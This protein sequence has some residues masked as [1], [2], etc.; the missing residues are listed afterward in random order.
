MNLSQRIRFLGSYLL[1]A[2]LIGLLR[3]F[4]LSVGL[5]LLM[6][7]VA[8]DFLSS[9]GIPLLF[10]HE[11]WWKQLLAGFF[12]AVAV[13][14]I[15][16]EGYLLDTRRPGRKWQLSILPSLKN[17]PL[18]RSKGIATLETPPIS[19]VEA[20][21][22][23]LTGVISW[24]GLT[25]IVAGIYHALLSNGVSVVDLSPLQRV[26]LPV[27]FAAGTIV[28]LWSQ[29]RLFA[30][31]ES[32]EEP[33]EK[34]GWAGRSWHG[35]E[36]FIRKLPFLSQSDLSISQAEHR[37]RF[38]SGI[39]LLLLICIYAFNHLL[40]GRF[41]QQTVTPAVALCLVASLFVAIYGTFVLL[42][43]TGP[44][45][46]WRSLLTNSSLLVVLFV[47]LMWIGGLS[48]YKIRFEH[49]E[50]YYA[51]P[52]SRYAADKVRIVTL[53][54]PEAADL[55][56]PEE[57][58]P[59][60][61]MPIVI[62]CSSGGGIRAAAWTMAI[63]GRLDHSLVDFTYHV[64]LM[65]GA[66]GGMLGNAYYATTVVPP[67]VSGPSRHSQSWVEDFYEPLSARQMVRNV[68]KDSLSATVKQML[69][70]DLTRVVLPVNGSPG[71]DRGGVL[72]DQW[73]RY[74]GT[75]FSRATFGSL[76]AGEQE[77]WRPTLV[78][79]P[80]L[81]EDGRRLLLTNLNAEFMCYN[82]GHLLGGIPGP[83]H[84]AVLDHYHDLY[85]QSAYQ[86]SWWFPQAF[87]DFPV[88][89]AARMSASFPYVSPAGVIPTDHRRRVV[90]AGYYDNY[91][92]STATG[93]IQKCLES[94]SKTD[95]ENHCS[96]IIIIQIRDSLDVLGGDHLN[97]AGEPPD[98][99]FARGFQ[100]LSSPVEAVMAARD[101]VSAFRNDA[102]LERLSQEFD[103][104]GYKDNFFT[105]ARFEYSGGVLTWYLTQR[106]Q[107]DVW[108]AASATER[109]AADGYERN[110]SRDDANSVQ[111]DALKVWWKDHNGSTQHALSGNE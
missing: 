82:G 27:G 26:W 55:L 61:R 32:L 84:I 93:W 8:C 109:Q 44:E 37:L 103:D 99:A 48:N 11:I 63:L 90:D 12:V 52:V 30:F 73:K 66:S 29:A 76:R 81:V 72:E 108:G 16:F 53:R 106:Q 35:G 7:T 3:H 92:L 49:L 40:S 38:L 59:S 1:D 5:F 4:P 77:R 18:R 6:A 50:V 100:W 79:S 10:W 104:R 36:E 20:R 111:M 14:I 95:L 96:G 51:Q 80:M 34:Q 87:D 70:G 88:S 89:T 105:T 46:R 31:I 97:L 23:V 15:L 74:L 85:S 17:R 110:P 39:V 54:Q 2:W 33:L 24:L 21:A 65:T 57:P 101:S 41:I 28:S 83:T 64:R 94:S 43:P 22:Y 47:V 78:F 13:V 9:L 75:A 67:S 91:G 45:G 19:L 42:V 98:P 71:I 58:D 25:L 69:F 62:V 102:S 56:G 60:K 107:A 68:S 86:F